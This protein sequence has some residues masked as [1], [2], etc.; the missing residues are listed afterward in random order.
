MSE[1]AARVWAAETLGERLMLARK[2]AGL[3]Q[4]QLAE[5]L[6]A[7]GV[8]ID[9]SMIT[10]FEADTRRPSFAHVWAIAKVLGVTVRDLGA[11]EEEYPELRF[12]RDPAFLE[13]IR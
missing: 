7:M 4:G 5:A 8:P 1:P 2:R 11:T 12:L 6:R 9:R 3:S 13:Q 10:R